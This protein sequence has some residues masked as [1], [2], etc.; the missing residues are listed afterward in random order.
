MWPS[1]QLPVHLVTFTE[2]FLNRKLHFFCSVK[3]IEYFGNI[4]CISVVSFI[5]ALPCALKTMSLKKCFSFHMTWPVW[6]CW[7]VLLKAILSI[8]Y[9]KTKTADILLSINQIPEVDQACCN[10][11]SSKIWR[12]NN[13]TCKFK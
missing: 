8:M 10:G 1:L 3:T 2:K 9:I 5:I 11:S 4:L 6:R 12:C 13:Q 7:W